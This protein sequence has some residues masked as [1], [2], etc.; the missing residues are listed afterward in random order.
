MRGQIIVWASALVLV[1]AIGVRAQ[2]QPQEPAKPPALTEGQQTRLALLL[3]TAEL[4]SRDAS[5]EAMAKAIVD[6][7]AA[8][9]AAV[10][11]AVT[12]LQTYYN[13]LQVPGW[14]LALRPDGEGKFSYAKTQAR[15]ET[16]R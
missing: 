9:Q 12:E 1:L 6:L 14:S 16:M 4:A 11:K 3:S 5:P 15:E 2:E 10:N 8:R 13:G 7:I